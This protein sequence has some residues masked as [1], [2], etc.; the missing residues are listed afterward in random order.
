MPG[1]WVMFSWQMVRKKKQGQIKEN[2]DWKVGVE[3]SRAKRF[4]IELFLSLGRFR[5][6]QG[7][8]GPA[9]GRGV[10]SQKFKTK[11]P[12]IQIAHRQVILRFP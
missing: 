11:K 12:W 2:T 8:G 9:P 5:P 6:Q 7:A 10:R 4:S 1:N 3:L